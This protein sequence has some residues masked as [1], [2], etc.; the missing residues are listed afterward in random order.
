MAAAGSAIGSWLFA[1]AHDGDGSRFRFAPL[2]GD[3]IRAYHS[4]ADIAGFPDS[5]VVRTADGRTLLRSEAALQIGE[6]LGGGWRVAARIV[7]LLPRLADRRGL[8]RCRPGPRRAVPEAGGE[9][10]R[11]CSP[12]RRTRF[13]P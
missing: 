4:P 2:Q 8:R 5:I 7:S 10:A 13:L 9:A 12:E 1:V 11:C 6:R 3:A